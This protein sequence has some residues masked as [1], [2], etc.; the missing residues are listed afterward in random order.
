[1]TQHSNTNIYLHVI[2]TSNISSS[3]GVDKFKSCV[4]H[5]SWT[6]ETVHIL[7]YIERARQ[8]SRATKKS[9]RA[10]IHLLPAMY[11]CR[12][13]LRARQYSNCCKPQSR[14]RNGP[15]YFPCST[16]IQTRLSHQILHC[17]IYLAVKKIYFVLFT[18]YFEYYISTSI[19]LLL[20]YFVLCTKAH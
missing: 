10:V 7:S 1:M 6:H 9:S 16:P 2:C 17:C 5:R 13:R 4:S 19:M 18:S 14:V 11:Y 8:D 12:T 20:K 15:P 3:S